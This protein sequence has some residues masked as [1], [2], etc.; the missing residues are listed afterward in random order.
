[1]D[2]LL[3]F[4]QETGSFSNESGVSAIVP[5]ALSLTP[6]TTQSTE[7]SRAGQLLFIDSTIENYQQVI[8]ATAAGIDVFVLDQQNGIGQISSILANGNYSNIDSL[9]IV[10]HGSEGA[11]HFGNSAGNN[12]VNSSNLNEYR[13]DL[14]GWAQYLS[15]DADILLYGCN[16]AADDS[17]QNFIES[18]SQ[19][20]GADVAASSD[21]S[22]NADS[23]GDWQLE[24]SVGSIETELAFKLNELAAFSGT[25]LPPGFQ[26]ELVISGLTQPLALENISP[27][28]MAIAFRTGE[29]QTF[30]PTAATPTLTNYLTLTDLYN[31]G[32][33]EVG[34]LDIKIDT[35]GYLYAY[36]TKKENPAID[37]GRARISRFN[38][39]NANPVEELVWRDARDVQSPALHLGGA[40][41]FGPD[42][43]IW[44]TTGDKFQQSTS[45]NLS[46]AGGKVIRV[47]KDGTIPDGTDGWA[48]NPYAV[49]N[50]PST[51]D[52][53]WASG[54]RNPFRA[55]WDLPSGR[56]FF[57]DVGGND[58]TGTDAS[59]E[60]I[61]VV[62]LADGGASYGWPSY[63]GFAQPSDPTPPANYVDPVFAWQHD[64]GGAAIIGGLA[65]RGNLFPT[66]Y[67]GAYFYSDFVAQ[68]IEYITFDANGDVVGGSTVPN[69]ASGGGTGGN[70][71]FDTEVGAVVGFETGLDGAL[72]YLD[73]NKR[74][75]IGN[76]RG[77][78]K[79]ITYSNTAGSAPVITGLTVDP[80]GPSD[81]PVSAP[82]SVVITPGQTVDFAISAND[83]DG[84]PLTYQWDFDRDGIFDD[85]TSVGTNSFTYTS[86]GSFQPLVV[87]SD[88]TSSDRSDDNF[89]FLVQV[90]TPPTIEITNPALPEIYLR[91]GE[92]INLSAIANDAEDGS[93]TGASIDW[94]LDLFHNDHDHLD[95]STAE[96]GTT[97]PFE[98][99]TTGH[100]EFGNTFYRIT[101]TAT[102]SDGLSATDTIIIR[103][104]ESI[105]TFTTLVSNTGTPLPTSGHIRLDGQPLGSDPFIYDNVI[106]YQDPLSADAVV[107]AAGA[108]YEFVSWFDGTTTTTSTNLLAI[109]PETDTT[110]TANYDLVNYLPIANDDAFNVA[111]NSGGTAL[112]VLAGDTDLDGT[113]LSLF[114]FFQPTNGTLT[115]DTKGTPSDTTDDELIYT[116]TAGFVGSE[117]FTYTVQDAF[118]DTDTAT[119]TV[120]VGNAPVVS[121]VRT[122]LVLELDADRG[123]T[124][125]GGQVTAWADQSGLGNDLTGAGDPQLA[126]NSLNNHNTIQFDTT[127]DKLDRTIDAL[128]GLPAG[129]SDRSVFIVAKYNENGYGGFG[130]GKTSKNNAFG[131]NVDAEGD[132]LVQGWGAGDVESTTVGTGAGWLTQTAIVAADPSGGAAEV[133]NHYK[134]GTLI[135]SETRNFNTVLE[136]LVVGSNLKGNDSIDMEVAEILVYNRAL[137]DAERQQ[138]ESYLQQKYALS[139]PQ[140]P[141]TP[142]AG[143]DSFTVSADTVGNILNVLGNDND[144]NGD[145]LTIT[146]ADQPTNGTVSINGGQNGIGIAYSPNAGYVGTDTFTYTISDG[147]NTDTATVT[148]TVEAPVT[149]GNTAPVATNDSFTVTE[150][151]TDNA[152]DILANDSDADFASGTLDFTSYQTLTTDGVLRTQTFRHLTSGGGLDTTPFVFNSTTGGGT[153]AHFHMMGG[154]MTRP[155]LT[156]HNTGGN[157]TTIDFSF[158]REDNQAFAFNGFDYTSGFFF[159]GTNADFTVTGTLAGGGTI[160]QTFGPAA[161]EQTFQSATLN[162]IGWNN[163]TSVN[164]TG[165]VAAT[166]T[167]V[168]QE[169]NIDNLDIS[170]AGNL[171]VAAVG[172]ANNGTVTINPDGDGITYTPNAGF[173]G[174]DNFSYTVT[175][176]T[177]T[178][179]AT[180][181][182]TVEDDGIPTPPTQGVYLALNND[183]TLG[184]T[185]I[186][187]EDI[188]LF[189]GTDF[190]LFFEGSDVG[191]NGHIDAFDVIS[192][193]EILMSFKATTTLAGVG[194]VTDGD[195]VKFTATSLGDN[196]AGS[197]SMFLQGSQ[198]GLTD[199][200][201][202]LS[203]LDD[204]SLLISADAK[205]TLPGIGQVRDEDVLRF[206]PTIA[207]DYSAGTWALHLDA[208][209][210]G[211]ASGSEN[212]DA[213]AV[214]A[215]GDLLI[216]TQGNFTVPGISGQDDDIL[217]FM[218]TSTTTGSFDT[219]LLLDGAAIGI[220]GNDIVGFDLAALVEEGN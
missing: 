8:K 186:A 171:N 21:I 202:A 92:L 168:T 47:N 52:S 183:Q 11:L 61:N 88:G 146:A 32:G 34:L 54:L 94:Q 41:D 9:Y 97:L 119:V 220:G 29:I 144:P 109:V 60:E 3:E 193:T 151:T 216:S 87:V 82:G 72:Y 27:T 69:A 181:T 200:I 125:N 195:I 122:G 170:A 172:T 210:V 83:P 111:E 6:T 28:Q 184:G 90:G 211:L 46:L 19:L 190:S 163:I 20:T 194:T 118:G 7:F 179:S 219:D 99:A 39:N 213:L 130:Y 22:G 10:S 50:D 62:T 134:D 73:V 48:A 112:D 203:L 80:T 85:T 214:N 17:G 93:L 44:L 199:G 63:E 104:L 86:A 128:S 148:V 208:G 114:S 35:D 53:I 177:D 139:G 124:T 51:L 30:D 197:F 204:G 5:S 55:S 101:A 96:I 158:E 68:T 191:F 141:Q 45:P 66:Q 173:Y 105:S 58:N 153:N 56:F 215:N 131:L 126:A 123:V 18:I 137:S 165:T 160:S 43:K 166:G 135:D 59:W 218:P 113:P 182:V 13:D 164:F 91:G 175:D 106:N 127:G 84:D 117:T 209:E 185:F 102:D 76:N 36:Y 133:V 79:R 65:Y 159:A 147:V 98:I 108:R 15:D 212:I 4:S 205:T 26:N 40:M 155:Y 2:N 16:V 152:L 37:V 161:A 49:D 107:I 145:P 67:Q 78:I 25:L 100:G 201:D 31:P 136:T 142:V 198:V 38:M 64:N 89:N 23:G 1:M 178:D 103:P 129:D 110:Y 143:E 189:D 81:P 42:G 150:N 57:G 120:Q 169:L 207:G 157:G 70:T 71:V 74:G 174:T 24:S 14:L 12:A 188:A 115:R 156:Q 217:G 95:A 180:V 121:P 75:S 187:N 138:V 154:M 206:T 33:K 149:T 116:P 162:G 196:T 77:A 132:L 167:T 140:T 192:T 176:G